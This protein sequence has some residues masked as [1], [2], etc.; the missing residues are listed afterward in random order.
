MPTLLNNLY[1]HLIRK[2]SDIIS[3]PNR[4]LC[5]LWYIQRGTDTKRL[6]KNIHIFF[7]NFFILFAILFIHLQAT[8]YKRKNFGL[9]RSVPCFRQ[10]IGILRWPIFILYG[11]GLCRIGNQHYLYINLFLHTRITC[12]LCY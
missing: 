12:L 1:I 5:K 11:R 2:I 10:L 3:K 9:H 6:L 4:R 8:K 7:N